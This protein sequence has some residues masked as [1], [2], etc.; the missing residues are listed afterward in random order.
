MKI[1][2]SKY[3]TLSVPV[4]GLASSLTR[5]KIF[6]IEVSV[7]KQLRFVRYRYIYIYIYIYNIFIY[8]RN[9]TWRPAV[10]CDIKGPTFLDNRLTYGGKVVSPKPRQRFTSQKH[11]FS[12]SGTHFC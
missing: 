9:R 3:Q 10:L 11:H 2:G 1:Q 5:I 6:L 8:P 4:S 12:A 7:L